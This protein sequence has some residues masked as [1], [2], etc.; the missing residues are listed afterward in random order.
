MFG[1]AK[2][3]Y[4]ALEGIGMDSENSYV[5][6]TESAAE[7][8]RLLDQDTLMTRALGGLLPESVASSFKRDGRLLDLGCG[9][10]GWAQEV[11]Y[12]FPEIEVVGVDISETMIVYAQA[13]ARVQHLEERVEFR[14][15]DITT[16]PWDF[17]DAS[18]DLVNARF[19]TGVLQRDRWPSFIAECTRLL[20]PGG[21]IRLTELIDS[22]VSTSPAFE[23]LQHLIYQALWQNGYGFSIDGR[24]LG[25]THA[26]PRMLRAAGY[27]QLRHMGFGLEFSV[28][29]PG[30]IDFYRNA[31]IGYRLG[32][33]FYIN[34]GVTTQE[35][36]EQL[37]QQMLIEMHSDDFFGMW[38]YMMFIGIRP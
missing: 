10:G 2:E 15:V 14:V 33:A 38:H 3:C 29:T 24:T 30:W 12:A 20:R 8:A 28:N 6:D 21:T 9:P 25:M 18:F 34:A 16:L 4:L 23:R 32:Q 22:G 31:E 17:P 11:L 27:Q 19:L 13:Q 5:I 26:L 1:D 36:F 35:E 7:M 37:Y